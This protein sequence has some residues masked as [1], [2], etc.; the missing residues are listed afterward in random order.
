MLRRADQTSV[1]SAVAFFRRK[2]RRR[3]ATVLRLFA[4]Q[5][6]AKTPFWRWL[7]WILFFHKK[8]IRIQIFRRKPLK[9]IPKKKLLSFIRKLYCLRK[10]YNPLFQNPTRYVKQNPTHLLARH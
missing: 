3:I 6:Q 8:S 10:S 9:K 4:K 2:K 1:A 7:F 5:I